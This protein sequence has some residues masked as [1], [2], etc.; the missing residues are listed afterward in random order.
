MQKMHPA[1]PT[2]PVGSDNGIHPRSVP[3]S[4]VRA[5]GTAHSPQAS[6]SANVNDLGTQTTSQVNEPSLATNGAN[7]LETWNWYSGISQDGGSTWT[8]Y[9]PASLFSNDYGGWCCD[10]VAEYDSSRDLY[11]W[12]LLYLPNANGG[13]LRLAVA[14]GA[15]DLAGASFHYWDLTP[16]QIGGATGDWYDYPKIALSS[17]DAYLQTNEYDASSNYVRTVVMRFSLDN[18]A[19]K[20]GGLDYTYFITPGVFSVTFTHGATDTM[21]FASHLSTDTLRVFFWAENSNTIFWNSVGHVSY[22]SAG[23]SC[24]RSGADNS[25]W[26]SRSDSRMLDGWVSN[27]VIGFSW[28]APQGKWGFNGTASYPYTDIVRI[29]QSNLAHID[30]PIVWN[31]GF[32]F[33]YMSHYP[34]NN[35]AVGGTFLYGGGS[36]FED[37]GAY[38]WDSNG[39]DFVGLV[40]SNQDANT[41]GDYLTTRPLGS[42]WGGTLYS[43]RDDGVHT[44]YATFGR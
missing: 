23:F 22:P 10:S 40:G 24:P 17:N 11:I 13:A 32:A 21:Y 29:N 12:N 5:S 33:M 8:Y 18:L 25:N 20:S 4:Q 30:D 1:L 27:G 31:S 2:V 3:A 14:D 19:N 6:V 38:V 7:V 39:R 34:N 35:G 42:S 43:V 26:C 36:L 16:Q 28:N 9:D 41:G 37:G 15:S 44:Y